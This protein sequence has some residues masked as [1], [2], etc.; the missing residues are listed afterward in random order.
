MKT[1][2][3]LKIAASLVLAVVS[4][5]SLVSCTDEDGTV[6][7]GITVDDADI[8]YSE[9]TEALADRVALD[10]VSYHFKKENK[11]EPNAE[12]LAWLDAASSGLLSVSG[13]PE[14]HYNRFL[15]YLDSNCTELSDLVLGVT[16]EKLAADRWI[17]EYLTLS[18]MI[19][20]EAVGKIVYRLIVYS[21]SFKYERQMKLYEESS[22]AYLLIKA[23]EYEEQK[24]VL[25]SEI[26]ELGAAQLIRSLTLLTLLY[27]DGGFSGGAAG[28]LTDAELAA[29]LHH[30][31]AEADIG[32]A[33]WE[34]VAYAVARTVSL[35]DINGCAGDL[36]A[37][38]IRSEDEGALG[39]AMRDTVKLVSHS[40]KNLTAD[41]VAAIRKGT[42]ADA[43]EVMLS[44][45]GDDE[46][47]IFEG[48]IMLDV[49]GERYAAVLRRYAQDAFE[50][51]EAGLTRVTLEELK[52]SVGT[53]KFVKNLEGYV[54][55]LS[56]ALA[57]GIDN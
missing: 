40:L 15:S 38:V 5:F 34:L 10:I 7:D 9:E 56:S 37:T 49:D 23:K 8:S 29:I 14:E 41:D 2:G 19:G 32:D 17:S 52:A 30:A 44:H 54:A 25:T 42:R 39:F 48:I 3:I 20:S 31:E 47:A 21:L 13:I 26:G 12:E 27:S 11:R 43:I 1:N 55:E 4:V 36:C 18:G 51:F 16:T 50:S 28:N 57:F 24:L 33:G 22:H 35:A 6:T 46:W 53:D 45:F